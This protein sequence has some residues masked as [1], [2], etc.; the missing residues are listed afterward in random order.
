[1]P[2]APQSYLISLYSQSPVRLPAVDLF[3]LV[4][5][6]T[7]VTLVTRFTISE[8]SGWPVLDGRVFGGRHHGVLALIDRLWLRCG[9]KGG[10]EELVRLWRV[11]TCQPAKISTGVSAL[12]LGI[13]SMDGGLQGK[14]RVERSHNQIPGK[15]DVC[16]PSSR[17]GCTHPHL[18]L[19]PQSDLINMATRDPKKQNL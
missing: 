18:T 1:M 14:R 5:S 16:Q 12:P 13:M 4:E 8:T 3:C 19:Q 15:Q 11:S 17:A 2:Y 6:F 9:C 7:L 10:L